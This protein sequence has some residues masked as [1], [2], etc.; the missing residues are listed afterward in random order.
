MG[1]KF[2]TAYVFANAVTSFETTNSGGNAGGFY[3][4]DAT[5]SSSRSGWLSV[6]IK[7]SSDPLIA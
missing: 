5:V 4:D 7:A 3:V 6:S 1:M 2:I